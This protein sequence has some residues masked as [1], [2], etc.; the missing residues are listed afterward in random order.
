MHIAVFEVIRPVHDRA[1][2]RL[3]R[4][5]ALGF[6]A[7]RLTVQ[8]SRP[9]RPSSVHV[10]NF[11][12]HDDLLANVKDKLKRRIY[13][14]Y[15]LIWWNDGFPLLAWLRCQDQF[16]IPQNDRVENPQLELPFPD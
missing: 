15:V 3:G 11:P 1:E 9:V 13:H 12:T 6:G 14:G 2:K 8:R 5:Y 16:E 4:R 10:E 7:T